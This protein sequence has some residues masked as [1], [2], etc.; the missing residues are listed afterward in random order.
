MTIHESADVAPDA[1]IDPTATV[2]HLAQVRERAMLDENVV[3]GRG[4]YI[5]TG[6]RVGANAKIQ[7]Y[8]LVYE[9]AII[10]QGA[11]I[12][13]AVVLTNDRNPRATNPDGLQ[14]DA[15][16]WQAVGVVVEQG[17]SIGAHAVCVAPVR[18]GAW[19]MVGAGSVV[20]SDVPAYGLVVG[21]PARLVGWVG[22]AGVRLVPAPG[23]TG[24]WSCPITGATYREEGPDTLVAVEES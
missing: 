6:V 19:S 3:V 13:P 23:G 15:A 14:K 4:A 1:V 2:W 20:T 10:E 11:F 16:D 9:P 7:N 5:G 22:R 24:E 8:A 18:L 21:C 12:G 17:A